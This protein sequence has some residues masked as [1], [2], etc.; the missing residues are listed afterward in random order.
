MNSHFKTD[1]LYYPKILKLALTAWCT[2]ILKD[3]NEVQLSKLIK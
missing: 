1:P 3:L 2:V